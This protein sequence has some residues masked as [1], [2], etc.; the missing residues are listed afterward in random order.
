[1]IWDIAV[2]DC[3]KHCRRWMPGGDGMH[4]LMGQPKSI[5]LRLDC[6][7]QPCFHF[8]EGLPNRSWLGEVIIAIDGEQLR[9]MA[10]VGLM[11]LAYHI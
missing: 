4:G 7:V 2:T 11:V 9:A 3:R 1:M 5:K 8:M 10:S 6:N